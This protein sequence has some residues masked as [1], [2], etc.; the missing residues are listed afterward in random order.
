VVTARPADGGGA[1][2]PPATIARDARAQEQALHE[3]LNRSNEISRATI[4]SA[5][6]A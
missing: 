4:V 5:G 6:G 3:I 2:S 1:W